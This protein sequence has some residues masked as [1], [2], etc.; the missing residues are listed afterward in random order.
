VSCDGDIKVGG[1]IDRLVDIRSASSAAISHL[2]SK[3]A[4][5]PFISAIAD[6]DTPG[7]RQ[8]ATA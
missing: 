6:N 3:L 7:A 4:L 2:R 1:A 5:M 8:A